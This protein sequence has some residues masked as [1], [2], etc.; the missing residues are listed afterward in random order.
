MATPVNPLPVTM[1]VIH[2]PNPHSTNLIMTEGPIPRP[3]G[4]SD[5]L[6]KVVATSPCLG[7]LHWVAAMPDFFP[8][9]KEPVPGQDVTGTV[10]EAA[11][12]S[13]FRPGDDVFGRI[14][15]T[16]PGGC[17][18]YA[19]VKKEEM[20]LK[21]AGLSW[22]EAAATPLSAL[23]AWQA[24]FTQGLLDKAAVFGDDEARARNG[25][26]AV[27]VAGAG[28]SVGTWA[29]QFAALA[30][31]R[32]VVALCSGSKADLMTSFGVTDVV[33]YTKTHVEA[34]VGGSPD[35]EVDL[36]VD[37]VGGASMGGLWSVVKNGGTFLSICADPDSVK[38]A[39]NSKK[40]EKAEWFIVESLGEQLGDIAQL[41]EA[42]R[43]R[44]V[45]DSVIPFEQFQEAF[46]KVESRKTKGK[47]IIRVAS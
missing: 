43:A 5:L 22:V 10:V 38:P 4:P 47:V 24:L 18:E 16:S 36:V 39:Q 28:T 15:A 35:R 34:W 19:V 2:Q 46:D 9:D 26:V 20:A 25:G 45:I 17:R 42:G 23:T 41:V 14:S 27:F 33:D 6:I 3:Q 8:A 12:E 13:G 7:E 30:G 37:C 31:A 1:R 11:A 32:K 29:V 44:P 40:L 21:P